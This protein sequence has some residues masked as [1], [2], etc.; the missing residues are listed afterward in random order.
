MNWPADTCGRP[1][2]TLSAESVLRIN[3]RGDTRIAAIAIAQSYCW[4]SPKPVEFG[5]AGQNWEN[6]GWKVKVAFSHLLNKVRPKDHMDGR[7]FS[8]SSI[9]MTPISGEGTIYPS[10]RI[11]AAWSKLEASAVLVLRRKGDG[12]VNVAGSTRPRPGRRILA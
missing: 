1:S 7:N 4:E 12:T 11:A 5:E 8:F 10:L 6:V 3:A 9:G 2:A